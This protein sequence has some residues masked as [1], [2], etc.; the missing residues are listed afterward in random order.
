MVALRLCRG[1][2]IEQCGGTTKASPGQRQRDGGEK[3]G[4]GSERRG[5][6]L[7][8]RPGSLLLFLLGFGRLSFF[9]FVFE[10]HVS[11]MCLFR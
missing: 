7:S 3:L 5:F 10:S 6:S 4:S 9:M 1:L 2:Q 8:A 11:D